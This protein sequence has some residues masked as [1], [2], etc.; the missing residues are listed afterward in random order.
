MFSPLRSESDSAIQAQIMKAPQSAY[1]GASP[2][3]K[4]ASIGPAQDAMAK[5]PSAVAAMWVATASFRPAMRLS[6]PPAAPRMRQAIKTRF[7]R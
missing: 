1:I 4:L 2:I 7:K 5:N 3:P 6:S